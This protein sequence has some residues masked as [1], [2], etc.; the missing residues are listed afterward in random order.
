MRSPAY[1]AAHDLVVVAPDGRIAAF[2]VIWPDA[3]TSLA[4]FEPVG[5]DPDF[6]RIGLA[7]R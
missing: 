5:T 7:P 1:V 4:Q 6:Q 3:E 2:T